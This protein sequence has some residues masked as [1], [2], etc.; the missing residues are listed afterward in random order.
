MVF[1][2][3]S[4]AE[5]LYFKNIATDAISFFCS[6]FGEKVQK[7]QLENPLNVL[8]LTELFQCTWSAVVLF[9][10]LFRRS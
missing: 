6:H 7:W 4:K 9:I 2:L 8:R 1:T 5:I 10:G 3:L